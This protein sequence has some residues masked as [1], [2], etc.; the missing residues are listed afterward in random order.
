MEHGVV[1]WFNPVKGFGFIAGSDG[2]EYF[3]NHS[4]ILMKGFRLLEA[5]QKVSYQI[6]T[7]EKGNK[8]INVTVVKLGGNGNE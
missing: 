1:K 8:A 6:E 5:G 4:N 2:K 7:V 3:V